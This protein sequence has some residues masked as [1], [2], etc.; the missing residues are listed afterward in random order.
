[1]EF[2]SV[3]CVVL[4]NF[5]AVISDVCVDSVLACDVLTVSIFVIL[6]FYAVRSV[7]I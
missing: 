7:F 4:T 3:C 6:V 5:I 1:M 2:N